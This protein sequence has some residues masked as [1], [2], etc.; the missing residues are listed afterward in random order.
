MD[1]DETEGPRRML[2]AVL[3]TDQRDR[4]ALEAEYG[5]CWDTSELSRDFDVLGFMAPFVVA[6]KKATREKGSL[7][8]RHAPRLYFNWMPDRR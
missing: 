8:F 7:E 1:H 3:N 5:R 6:V 2:Q 4:A